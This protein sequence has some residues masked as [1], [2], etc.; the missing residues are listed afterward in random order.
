MTQ[1][2]TKRIKGKKSHFAIEITLEIQILI[3]KFIFYFIQ[4]K[5]SDKNRVPLKKKYFFK[6]TISQNVQKKRIQNR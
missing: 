4:N 2:K 1:S 6:I 3:K 5:E